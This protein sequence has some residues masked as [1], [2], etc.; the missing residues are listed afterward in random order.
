[1]GLE[2]EDRLDHPRICTALRHDGEPCGKFAIQGGY[3]CSMHGGNAPQVLHKARA[4]LIEAADRMAA[5]LLGMAEDSSSEAVKLNAIRDAL[6]RA[7]VSA[8][9]E[10]T[11]ELKPW[12]RLLQDIGITGLATVK[13][14][15]AVDDQ[16]RQ[17]YVIEV[18][19]VEP[20]PDIEPTP[21]PTI[22]PTSV[23]QNAATP[24]PSLSDPATLMTMEQASQA[25][26]RYRPWRRM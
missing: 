2:Y 8:K 14:S 21:T 24:W 12:E 4:R 9:N 26:Q 23:Q 7:G 11:L 16:G 15:Q 25:N 3:V 1:M 13:R 5:A 18:D 17:P 20:E 10:L 6:D 19:E 22:E